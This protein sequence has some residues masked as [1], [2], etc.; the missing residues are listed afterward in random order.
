ML[1]LHETWGDSICKAFGKLD[2]AISNESGSPHTTKL[3]EVTDASMQ[4]TVE[5]EVL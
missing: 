5:G 4:A 3:W 1:G 2:I